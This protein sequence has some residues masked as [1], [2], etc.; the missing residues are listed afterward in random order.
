MPDD[1]YT[2]KEMLQEVR[3]TQHEQVSRIASI[4]TT[5]ENISKHLEQLNSKV[6][7]HEKRLADFA[8]FRDKAMV[9]WGFIVFFFSISIN[10]VL[11]FFGL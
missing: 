11:S 1:S 7:R 2:L 3:M 10:K 9:V 8:T 5:L 4:G 6:A